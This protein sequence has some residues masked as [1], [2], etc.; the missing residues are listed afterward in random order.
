MATYLETYNPRA[1]VPGGSSR[2]K[3]QAIQRKGG[4]VPVTKKKNPYVRPNPGGGSGPV[5][6]PSSTQRPAIQ[7]P[8]PPTFTP[9]QANYESDPVLA[10]IRALG[11]QNVA[12]AQ[13]EAAALRKQAIIDT[14]L[15]DVGKEIGLDEQTLQA[16]QANP[17]SLLAQLARDTQTQ[18]HNLDES[19]NQQNLFWSGARA[20]KL[21]ELG[22]SQAAA[23]AELVR[24][25][26]AALGGIDSGVL[27]AQQLA[28]QQEQAALEEAAAAQQEQAM[29]QAYFDS[30]SALFAPAVEETA[31]V[32]DPLVEANVLTPEEEMALLL[33][34]L[35]S[36]LGAGRTYA[37]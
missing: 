16:A 29:Q 7:A 20:T 27:E 5:T 19:L 31:P 22:Q 37:L 28:A 2:R 18:S 15:T 10:R 13:T 1:Y 11:T 25:L 8:P 36:G 33:T 26:R 3:A 12:N 4:L 34:G 30:L 23:Q 9:L 17:L 6:S 32:V 35:G 21:G 24:D 14:G